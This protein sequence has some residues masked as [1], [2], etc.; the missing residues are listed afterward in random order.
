MPRT[1]RY[2]NIAPVSQIDRKHHVRTG[3]API[4]ALFCCALLA[5]FPALTVQASPDNFVHGRPSLDMR[6][7]KLVLSLP[8][9]VDNEDSL[10]EM[11]RDGSTMELSIN[12]TIQRKRTLWFNESI[13]EE[14]F[15]FLLRHDPL[16]REYRMSAPGAEQVSQDKSLRSLLTRTW[17]ILKLPLADEAL[18]RPESDYQVKIQL[19][20]KHTALPP[21]LDRTLVFWNKDV[22]N[23][24]S[25]ELE[26][27]TQDAPIPR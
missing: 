27:R 13:Y 20:L 15:S 25:L 26:Y 6:G 17:K 2:A 7:G 9:S 3:K 24:I 16:S 14:I 21:W 23:P 11:L 12:V 4:L 10:G 5:V 22:V 8:L 1:G 18:F 19:S